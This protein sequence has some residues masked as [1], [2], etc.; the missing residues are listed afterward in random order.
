MLLMIL[1]FMLLVGIIGTGLKLA[2]GLAKFLFG[3][4]LFWLCPALFILLVFLGAFSHTWLFILI[5]GL[6]FGHGFIR[7]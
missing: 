2:W 6:L 1:M 5:L 4:G 7:A 3:L